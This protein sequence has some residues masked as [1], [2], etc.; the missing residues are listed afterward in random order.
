MDFNHLG[1]HKITVNGQ[2]NISAL[3][4]CH[5][6]DIN[7]QGGFFF[8][9]LSVLYQLCIFRRSLSKTL[10]FLMYVSHSNVSSR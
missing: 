3:V 6:N 1:T 2:L 5:L 9:T 7:T 8:F 4:Y 10:V